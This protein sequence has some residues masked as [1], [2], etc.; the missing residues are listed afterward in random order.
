MVE[1]PGLRRTQLPKP[2]P[3]HQLIASMR[4]MITSVP[5]GSEGHKLGMFTLIL[6]TIINLSHFYPVS[7][8]ILLLLKH[9]F[10]TLLTPYISIGAQAWQ[11]ISRNYYIRE[12]DKVSMCN[13][14]AM[15]RGN[16][17]NLCLLYDN[18]T[19]L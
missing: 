4:P 3:I 5:E 2:R 18:T 6:T 17:R 13:Q 10:F 8:R 11:A 19:P 15:K 9:C 7:N 14:I 12:A 16:L 1:S